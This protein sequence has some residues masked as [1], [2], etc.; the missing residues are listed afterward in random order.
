MLKE[1]FPED[2]EGENA[3]NL[4][5]T[6]A[7]PFFWGGS[8]SLPTATYRPRSLFWVTTT[9]DPP[10]ILDRSSEG[11][12]RFIAVLTHKATLFRKL[13]SLLLNIVVLYIKICSTYS[14]AGESAC[15]EN[16]D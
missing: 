15:K 4:S 8:S 16:L 5:S 13:L 3:Q 7:S 6:A 1:C 12:P 10:L 2:G 9:E 11:S 14:G